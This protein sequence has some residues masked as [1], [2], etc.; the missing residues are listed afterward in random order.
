MRGPQSRQ[1]RRAACSGDPT[2]PATAGARVRST[3]RCGGAPPDCPADGRT[4]PAAPG[5]Q[6]GRGECQRKDDKDR[7]MRP[8]GQLRQKI[9]QGEHRERADDAERGPA[10]R[11]NPLPDNRDARQSQPQAQPAGRRV[12]LGHALP[13]FRGSRLLWGFVHGSAVIEPIRDRIHRQHRL[14]GRPGA[15]HSESG[16]RHQNLGHQRPRI[17]GRTSS[18]RRRR[19]HW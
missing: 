17:V 16:T 6:Q 15:D 11:P 18:L 14:V 19:R 4:R 1:R 8:S 12:E 7:G 3:V 5:P 2:V 13:R 10:R 9:E